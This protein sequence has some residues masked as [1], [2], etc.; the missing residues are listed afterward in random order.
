MLIGGAAAGIPG[1]GIPADDVIGGAGGEGEGSG[2]AG[3]NEIDVE[4]CDLMT[5]P[6][7]D[8]IPPSSHTDKMASCISHT[9]IVVDYGSRQI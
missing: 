2:T 5:S 3:C 4:L 1:D 7:S 6:M 9:Y 8:H